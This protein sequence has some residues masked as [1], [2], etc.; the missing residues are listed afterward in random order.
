SSRCRHAAA[1]AEH[2]TRPSPRTRFSRLQARQTSRG[3]LMQMDIDCVVKGRE[4]LGECPLWDERAQALWWVDILAP[5]LKRFDGGVKV[6]PLTEAMGIFAFR[7]T[8]GLVAAMKSGIYFF[9]TEKREPVARPEPHL[10]QNRFNDG[11][12]DRDGRFW[13]G[14]MPEPMREPA[15]S[16]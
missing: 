2:R 3:I 7:E 4:L 15:G 12:C 14:T 9:D 1:P 6:F 10:P 16:L 5:S 11:R 8:G 13:S